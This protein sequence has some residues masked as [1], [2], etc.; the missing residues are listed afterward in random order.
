MLVTLEQHGYLFAEAVSRPK[1]R[2]P[3][4][5]GCSPRQS[6]PTMN[7]TEAVR[8]P[9]HRRLI[10]LPAD[11]DGNGQFPR[12]FVLCAGNTEDAQSW[13]AYPASLSTRGIRDPGQA[14]NALTVGAY[15]EKVTI[16]EPDAQGL[17][18]PV[19]PSGGL[20]PYTR[21]SNGLGLGVALEARRGLRRGQCWQGRALGA[22]SASPASPADDH[23]LPL[24][25]LFTTTNATS[26]ASALGARMAAQLMAAYPALR[27]ETIRALIVHS[28]EWTAAMRACYLPAH[29]HPSKSDYVNLI[30]H[31]GWGV[32]EPGA[33]A[34]ERR[35]LADAGRRRPW[36]TR[37]RRSRARVSSAAT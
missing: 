17:G 5:L 27:P 33:C 25:R 16:T 13:N 37:T 2:P 10:D 8:R 14:W 21:T 35:Q 28:A 30:R 24:E 19:A 23:N 34:V 9:G 22:G 3:I 6:P 20:S 36:C 26:A 11:Y 1:S 32:P 31:C 12:L 18:T 7:A 4:D 29:G 15:T